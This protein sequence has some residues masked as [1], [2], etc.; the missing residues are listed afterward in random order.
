MEM[1]GSKAGGIDGHL[2]GGILLFQ[3]V[4]FGSDRV[5][6]VLKLILPTLSFPQVSGHT[7]TKTQ[8]QEC[9]YE[10]LSVCI[11]YVRRRAWLRAVRI[12]PQ[13]SLTSIQS[14]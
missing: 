9:V 11:L 5:E 2:E 8:C 6:L 14:L 10:S 3:L 13:S 12:R 1:E 4:D 7:H